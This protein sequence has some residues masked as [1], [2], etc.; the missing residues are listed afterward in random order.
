[1]CGCAS[2][3]SHSQK[4]TGLHKRVLA[5]FLVMVQP[6]ALVK[7]KTAKIPF[8]CGFGLGSL[9]GIQVMGRNSGWPSCFPYCRGNHRGCRRPGTELMAGQAA[10]MKPLNQARS[11]GTQADDSTYRSARFFFEFRLHGGWA[12]ERCGR[13]TNL[14]CPRSFLAGIRTGDFPPFPGAA[15]HPL[16]SPGNF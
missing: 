11:A 5:R 7:T 10:T 12:C 6:Q 16:R 2:N 14:E 9:F 3:F 8:A 15:K 1:M 13:N 4:F